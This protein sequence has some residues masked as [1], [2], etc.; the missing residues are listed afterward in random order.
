MQSKPSNRGVVLLMVLGILALLSVLAISFVQL[1]QLE[2]G[3]SENYVLRTR[4]RMAAESGLEYAVARLGDMAGVLSEEDQG[5]LAWEENP[6]LPGLQYATKLSFQLPGVTPLKSGI[7]GSSLSQ[8]GD[9]FKLAVTDESSKLNLNDSNNPW[10]I[11]TDP[12][13]DGGGDDPDLDK[14]QPRRMAELI[15]ELGTVLFGS[16]LTGAEIANTLFDES[17]PNSRPNLPGGLFDSMDQVH[18]LLVP[19]VLDETQYEKLAANVTIYNWQDPNVIRPTY[20][21]EIQSPEPAPADE[22]NIYIYS[23]FQT[24]HFELEP[25][26]PININTA[27]QEL[28]EAMIRPI[29][30]WFLY[31]GAP[32]SLM[33]GAHGPW[34]NVQRH[35][36]RNFLDKTRQNGYPGSSE[37]FPMAP[38]WPGFPHQSDSGDWQ[39]GHGTR[40]GQALRTPTMEDIAAELAKI[41]WERIHKDNPATAAGDDS[42]PFTTWDEFTRF[43][44]DL[45][46]TKTVITSTLLGNTQTSSLTPLDLDLIGDDEAT[47][48]PYQTAADSSFASGVSPLTGFN[49]YMADALLA[50]FNPN[51]QLNDHNPD[52]H[53]FRH[54]DKSQL[55]KYST[56]FSFVPTGYFHVRSLGACADDSGAQVA[57]TEIDSVLKVFHLY[58]QTSQAQFMRGYEQ[59][60]PGSQYNLFYESN[61]INPT[62][63]ADLLETDG[64]IPNDGRWGTSVTSYPDPIRMPGSVS[65]EEHPALG[66]KP[67]TLKDY[68]SEYEGYLMLSTYQLDKDAW[69]NYTGYQPTFMATM[70]YRDLNGE[71]AASWKTR[72]LA[73]GG[74]MPVRYGHS[75]LGVRDD[76]DTLSVDGGRGTVLAWIED[77]TR[78]DGGI[79]PAD[80][81]TFNFIMGEYPNYPEGVPQDI[82][83][84]VNDMYSAGESPARTNRKPSPADWVHNA[85]WENHVNWSEAAQDNSDHFEFSAAILM[86]LSKGPLNPTKTKVIRPGWNLPSDLPVTPDVDGGQIQGNLFPDGVFSDTGRLLSYPSSNMGSLYGSR[87]S[88][89]FWFKPH[90]DAGFSNRIRNIFNVGDLTSVY[91]HGMDLIYFPSSPRATGAGGNEKDKSANLNYMGSWVMDGPWC[92]AT[93]SFLCGYVDI[94]WLYSIWSHGGIFDS[95]HRSSDT[96]TD[97]FPFRKGEDSIPKLEFYG[98]QW[99]HAAIAYD[100]KHYRPKKITNNSGVDYSVFTNRWDSLDLTTPNTSEGIDDV[101]FAINGQVIL[102][103]TSQS[104]YSNNSYPWNLGWVPIF[105]F[106][107]EEKS[108]EGFPVHNAWTTKFATPAGPPGSPAKPNAVPE[109]LQIGESYMRFG[110]QSENSGPTGDCTYDDITAW[111]EYLGSDIPNYIVSPKLPGFDAYWEQG[112]YCAE[113]LNDPAGLNQDCVGL[114]TSAPVN[115]FREIPELLLQTNSSLS[116]KSV[117]WTLYWPRYNRRAFIDGLHGVDVDNRTDRLDPV[118]GAWDPVVVDVYTTRNKWFYSQDTDDDD[119]N[120]FNNME[121]MAANAGDSRIDSSKFNYRNGDD[122]RYRLYFN[123]PM[124][125]RLME[126]PVLDDITFIFSS[127][128]PIIASYKVIN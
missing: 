125:E 64:G 126:S 56:E 9:Y 26:S 120:V 50:N 5:T 92:Q 79:L 114:F 3:I 17:T 2:R 25:R 100:A 28:I 107:W 127:S 61:G 111:G 21:C 115:L 91:T 93:H 71:P 45:V 55:T 67:A 109:N 15:K 37:Y 53:L 52:F 112:R 63:G 11:D 68:F 123:I 49:R 122:F 54:V 51:S 106:W 66:G 34:I 69:E 60:N 65:I 83:D 62:A 42:L 94:N 128:K 32:C 30:G 22:F 95:S 23:D 75:P 121:G 76:L 12:W 97:Y 72:S 73:V 20:T 44:Y 78:P 102:S 58:R 87:G 74:M 103:P 4:T 38:I 47:R 14:A 40:Y 1:S 48:F 99:N 80:Q 39:L 108:A 59:N 90:W 101:Q 82:I 118:T 13:Q 41:L 24:R 27:S 84:M 110:W 113:P 46:D 96:A 98:H 88:I 57:A 36:G 85:P 104:F 86:P 43:L 16:S 89:A 117:H 33:D 8:D 19:V 124:G 31:E 105:D 81:S 77:Y 70:G 119:A 29:E 6:A 10:N 116:L 35:S 18:D 7:V